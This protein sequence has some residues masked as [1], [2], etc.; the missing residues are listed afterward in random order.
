MA[1][2]RRRLGHVVAHIVAPG[3]V[4]V[5]VDPQSGMVL[6]NDP[7]DIAHRRYC[8]EGEHRAALLGLWVLPCHEQLAN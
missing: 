5:A 1:P 2:A 4:A 3:T 8:A 6:S 7:Q